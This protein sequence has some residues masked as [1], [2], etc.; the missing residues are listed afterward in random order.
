MSAA[1]LFCLASSREGWPNVVNESLACGTPVVATDIGGVP[2]M[3]PS[4]EYGL[5]VPPNDQASLDQALC[6][7]FSMRWDREAIARWGQSRSWEHVASEVLQQLAQTL[8][9]R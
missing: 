2:D 1:D 8:R 4:P 3:L 6:H 5:I 7:A 9:S